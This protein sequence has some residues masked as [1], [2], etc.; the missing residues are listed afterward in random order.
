MDF[1][2]PNELY[3]FR[4]RVLGVFKNFYCEPNPSCLILENGNVEYRD[5]YGEFDRIRKF[6]INIWEI[7]KEE[8]IVR[9]SIKD[10]VECLEA[11]NIR[12]LD[13]MELKIIELFLFGT[14][15]NALK[16][17]VYSLE[18]ED[19]YFVK[20]VFEKIQKAKLTFF[21]MS[22]DTKMANN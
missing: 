15:I 17:I 14:V 3:K 5:D 16:G 21:V 13:N 11:V 1:R 8:L 22:E 6:I 10:F 20:K 18:L 2:N 7:V 4:E 19:E 12:D 9:S